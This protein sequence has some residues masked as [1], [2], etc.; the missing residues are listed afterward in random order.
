M[1]FLGKKNSSSCPL[2]SQRKTGIVRPAFWREML[3]SGDTPFT[4]A[5]DACAFPAHCTVPLM[6]W[7]KYLERLALN[8]VAEE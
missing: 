3:L 6:H 8:H 4:D 5:D 7:P 1:C 2:L